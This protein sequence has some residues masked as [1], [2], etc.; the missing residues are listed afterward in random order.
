[1]TPAQLASSKCANNTVC[2]KGCKVAFDPPRA[3]GYFERC[4]L[5]LPPGGVSIG[6]GHLTKD[7]LTAGQLYLTTR[8]TGLFVRRCPDCQSVLPKRRR[9]CRECAAKRHVKSARE[10]ARRVRG[11]RAVESPEMLALPGQ[12]TTKT[13]RAYPKG[14]PPRNAKLTVNISAAGNGGSGK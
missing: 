7:E 10:S 4:V 1:M 2:R 12:G 6:N 14:T 3:C 9:Y 11:A 8:D 5:A 13:R